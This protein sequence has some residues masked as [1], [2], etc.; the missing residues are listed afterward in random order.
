MD[1]TIHEVA[2][3]LHERDDRDARTNPHQPA[4]GAVVIDTTDLDP[5]AAF[6]AA[7]AVVRERA[8]E[9]LP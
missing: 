4:P 8:P 9:L 5:A 2:T 6:E 7:L 1:R 3:A